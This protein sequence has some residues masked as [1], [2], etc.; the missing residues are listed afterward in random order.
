VEPRPEPPDR[1]RLVLAPAP[2][3]ALGRIERVFEFLKSKGIK[4]AELYGYPG[5]PFPTATAG[6]TGNLAGLLELRALGD[7]YGIR[8]S[9]R[10]GSLTEANWDNQIAASRILGQDHI[11][12][13][14]LP[15]AGTAGG[16]RSGP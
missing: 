14:G 1:D 10:H 3:T 4:Y 13:S 9:G 5:N 11:G 2:A 12:E 7:R 16:E 6:S 15:G 8:F